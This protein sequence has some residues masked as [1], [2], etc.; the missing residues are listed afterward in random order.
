M[1]DRNRLDLFEKQIS[2][3]S[4][5]FDGDE[6]KWKKNIMFQYILNPSSVKVLV[7]TTLLP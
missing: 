2:V 6:D 1:A 5:V 3:D 4:V 7:V